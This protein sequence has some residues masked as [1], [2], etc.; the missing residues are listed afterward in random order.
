M[1]AILS[2]DILINFALI[3]ERVCHFHTGKFY[4]ASKIFRVEYWQIEALRCANSIVFIGEKLVWC[5]D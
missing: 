2:F 1:S 3:K 5:N 4:V